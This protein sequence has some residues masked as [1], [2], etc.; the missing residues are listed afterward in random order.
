[1]MKWLGLAREAMLPGPESEEMLRRVE[2]RSVVVQLE[3]VLSFPMVRSRVERGELFLHG[4]HYMIETGE[5]LALDLATGTFV[6][7]Q[8]EA[9]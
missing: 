5:V 6:P 3:H 2:Q 9:A 4:W 1:M 7:T 8:P